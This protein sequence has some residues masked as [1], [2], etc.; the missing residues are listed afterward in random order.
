MSTETSLILGGII[1]VG[2]LLSFA[3]IVFLF[4]RRPLLAATASL[5]GIAASAVAS[6]L[7]L[8]S[9]SG[10]DFRLQW[11][12]AWLLPLAGGFDI[13]I[14]LDPLSLVMAWVVSIVGFLVQWYSNSYMEHDERRGKFFAFLSLFCFAMLGF[15]L[16][17]SLFQSYAFW[18]L[19]GLGSY[20]LIGFWNHL[21]SA[22]TAARK[23]FVMTRLG[24][25][26]F[27]AAILIVFHVF[28]TADFAALAGASS[29]S[30]WNSSYGGLSVA[31]WVSLGLFLAIA[32][33]S[34]QFPLYGWLPDA[35][36][37]PTPVSALIHAA[38][39]VAA[40][41]YLLAR[42]FFLYAGGD[43]L[44]H[45]VWHGFAA[46]AMLTALMSNLVAVVQDDIKR[47][48]AYSTISQLGYMV[49]GICTGAM[50]AGMSHLFTHAFF[51]ALLFLTAGVFIHAVHSNSIFD[52]AK[53]GG[54]SMKLATMAL[55]AGLLSL[56]G[57]FPFAG[58]YSK[59]AILEHLLVEQHWGLF[60]FA[61]IGVFVTGYYS[62]R[63]LF[64]LLADKSEPKHPLHTGRWMVLP[65][66]VLILGAVFSG[67]L[68]SMFV[69]HWFGEVEHAAG[70]A[71]LW[72][73]LLSTLSA[74]SGLLM[75]AR[76]YYWKTAADW[77]AQLPAF[78]E[79]LREKW[80]LDSAYELIVRRIYL[81]ITALLQR[82]E[83]QQV[84]GALDGI[85]MSCM[86]AARALARVQSGEL[87]Q[88]FG[89]MFVAA[90]AVILLVTI[91]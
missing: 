5:L 8:F 16:S 17:P 57:I 53:S 12:T 25:L 35:M 9:I 19:V 69:G 28:Q 51:K 72:T 67:N 83:L 77:V 43:E 82:F 44:V 45:T 40:G 75:A 6:S 90:A 14:L 39:M 42:T 20:L 71:V 81:P 29:S 59:D 62:G 56:C 60:A 70:S 47:V 65:L 34:A 13:G 41:V 55:A 30:L 54:R 87:Q 15:A 78:A 18:E 21:P 46:V 23:A 73:T 49:V 74:V 4:L 32:G 61:L 37:G 27:F 63:L 86:G 66:L 2:P 88:Y 84:K 80:Y 10:P 3:L 22:A 58:F 64:I 11:S 26:G 36:E 52:I 85:G 24:D 68:W 7:L 79:I 38:T 48:L 50:L 1:V 33:K 89:V 31:A 76:T 91:W